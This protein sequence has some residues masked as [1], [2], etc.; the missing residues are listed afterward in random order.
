MSVIVLEFDYSDH[1]QLYQ[2]INSERVVF[3]KSFVYY[4]G[5]GKI[6]RKYNAINMSS[7][8]LQA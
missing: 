7:N 8:I 2:L 4:R 1:Q 5:L 6:K 3:I